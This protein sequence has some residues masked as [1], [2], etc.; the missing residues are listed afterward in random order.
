MPTVPFVAVK[1][2][3]VS[4]L[5]DVKDA[6][7]NLLTG[8]AANVVV[9][10][11]KKTGAAP[12]SVVVTETTPAGNYLATFTPL[13]GD[14]TPVSYRLTLNEPASSA[15]REWDFMIQSFGAI[16][17]LQGA[18]GPYLTSLARVRE[19]LK[20]AVDEVGDDAWITNTIAAMTDFIQK[21]TGRHL[22]STA[23]T[24]IHDG[25][26]SDFFQSF[27]RPII[28]VTAIYQ[29]PNQQ[30]DATSLVDPA[31]YVVNKLAGTVMKKWGVPWWP[32]P[33]S[34]RLDAVWGFAQVPLSLELE[35]VRLVSR[36]WRR[37]RVNEGVSNRRS[38]EQSISFYGEQDM[39]IY[40]LRVLADWMNEYARIS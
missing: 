12:E 37:G 4:C 18:A 8:Q 11:T 35:C 33:Q 21:K 30:F 32:W 9:A 6:N 26:G 36:E 2:Q 39:E 40:D 38:K 14:V 10:L 15:G 5:F 29:S 27:D 24:E 17:Q 28:S 1:G 22:V 3:P 20:L 34:I 19:N 13:D 16:V 31:L 23:D 25:S 7:Y